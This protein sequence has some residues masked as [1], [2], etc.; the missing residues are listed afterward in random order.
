MRPQGFLSLARIGK[1]SEAL[2][3]FS[4]KRLTLVEGTFFTAF[5]WC[6]WS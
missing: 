6:S 4:E 5:I 3:D 1:R 2:A